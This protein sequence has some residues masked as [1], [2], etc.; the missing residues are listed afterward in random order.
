VLCALATNYVFGL[1]K[2][3]QVWR[4]GAFLVFYQGP[5]KSTG[6]LRGR[7]FLFEMKNVTP[8]AS[9]KTITM[10]MSIWDAVMCDRFILD[11]LWVAKK[12]T[13]R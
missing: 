3:L 1:M 5:P 11:F 10:A 12:R 13:A 7:R 8:A 6:G 9:N 2:I 4:A